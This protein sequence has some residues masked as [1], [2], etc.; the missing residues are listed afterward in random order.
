MKDSDLW[1]MEN[2]WDKPYNY[3]RIL[4][5]ESFQDIAQGETQAEFKWFCELWRVLGSWES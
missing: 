4:P 1:E 5:W 3:S 2:K